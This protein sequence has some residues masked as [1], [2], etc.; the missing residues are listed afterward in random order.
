M[1][2]C[3]IFKAENKRERERKGRA[4]FNAFTRA[5]TGSICSF[6]YGELV[7]YCFQRVGIGSL[8]F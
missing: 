8:Q 6:V 2:I 7:C 1:L 4:L 3:R 5:K